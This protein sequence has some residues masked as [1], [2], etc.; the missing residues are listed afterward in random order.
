MRKRIEGLT[1][2][3]RQVLREHDTALSWRE[4]CL[5]IRGKCLVHIAPEQEEITYDQ[6]NFYHSVRRMLTGLVRRGEVA[7]VDRGIYMHIAC[8]APN[9]RTTF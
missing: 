6:P 8:P 9:N 3:I 2:A 4:I 7:R 5:E 1:D